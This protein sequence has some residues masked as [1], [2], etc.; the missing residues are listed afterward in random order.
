MTRRKPLR[1]RQGEASFGRRVPR[2]NFAQI[3]AEVEAI[4]NVSIMEIDDFQKV[5]DLGESVDEDALNSAD[6][7]NGK[8][9]NRQATKI[10][11]PFRHH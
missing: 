9:K 2:C 4:G 6:S 11:F 7:N 8:N 1:F 3:K 5:R 10:R